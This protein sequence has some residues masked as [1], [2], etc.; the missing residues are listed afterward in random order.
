MKET[1]EPPIFSTPVQKTIFEPLIVKIYTE[2]H[3]I[4]RSRGS[5]FQDNTSQDLRRKDN[6][7][8][9]NR[10]FSPVQHTERSNIKY[11]MYQ[12]HNVKMLQQQRAMP[13]QK[14]RHLHLDN[15]CPVP[16]CFKFNEPQKFFYA[17]SQR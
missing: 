11:V 2:K 12:S 14:V 1:H 10:N 13:H 4:W 3:F 15:R 7:I 9:S 5:K 6:T 16:Q 8:W 17:K